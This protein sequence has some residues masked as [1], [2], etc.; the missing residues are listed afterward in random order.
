MPHPPSFPRVRFWRLAI[1]LAAVFLRLFL[2]HSAPPGLTHD[3]ADHG[4]TAWSIVQGARPLYIAVANGREPLYDYA[5]AVV[6][7]FIGPSGY[8]ARLT[9]A[10]ASLLLLA[11]TYAWV[12]RALGER[13]ALFTMALFA[14]NFWAVMTARQALRSITLPVLFLLALALWWQ[15]CHKRPTRFWPLAISAGLTLGLTFYTYFPARLLWL[16]FPTA[17]LWWRLTAPAWAARAWR[18]TLIMLAT[19]A[20]TAAPLFIFLHQ[21]PTAETRLGQ[22]AGP[23]E[24][25]VAGDLAPLLATSWAGLQTLTVAGA[26][27]SAWRYNIA[28]QPLLAPLT[29]VLG[30]AGV[31]LALWRWRNPVYGV[32]GL[33]FVLGLAPVLATGA[34]LSATRAIALQPVLFIFPALTLEWLLTYSAAALENPKSKIQNPPS[35][36]PTAAWLAIGFVLVWMG[37]QTAQTYFVDWAQNPEVRL[38]YEAAVVTAVDYVNNQPPLTAALSVP[39]PD[40]YHAQPLGLL[41]LTQRQ[42]T[43]HWFQGQHSLLLPAGTAASRFIFVGSAQPSAEILPFMSTFSRLATVPQPATD[44]D[45]PIVVYTADP[46]AVRDAWLTQMNL[47]DQQIDITSVLRLHGYL[48]QPTADSLTLTTLWEVTA[49]APAEQ[50]FFAQLLGPTGTPIAQADQ[51]D[52][53]SNQWQVGDWFLQQ[54]ILTRPPAGTYPLIIGLYDTA[55][56]THRWPITADG[57]PVGDF[58][59]LT[60]VVIE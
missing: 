28:G 29:A 46:T 19:A 15:A 47:P 27:D 2:L 36:V 50:R 26:G 18:P 49:P 51:L 41:T 40:Q 54:H 20:L 23:L 25:A 9:A 13:V 7:A 55:D 24:A 53:P 42:S 16:L 34:Y 37:L 32:L 12:R 1:L 58:Y 39:T 33:W 60:A 10:Y 52:V 44:L 30:Y 8:A 48:I 35:P 22:L 4:L 38:Q 59:Q 6:M 56:P 17:V 5:T 21:N 3:E 14:L 31:M 45:Q 57:T 11:L 43:L